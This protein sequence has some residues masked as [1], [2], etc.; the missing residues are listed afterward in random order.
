MYVCTIV[1]ALIRV[2]YVELSGRKI[3]LGGS[4]KHLSEV[5][6]GKIEHNNRTVYVA[7]KNPTDRHDHTLNR[8]KTS[9]ERVWNHWKNMGNN[10]TKSLQ[11]FWTDIMH[12]RQPCGMACCPDQ[13]I[14]RWHECALFELLSPSQSH[15]NSHTLRTAL[16]YLQQHILVCLGSL[17][18]ALRNMHAAAVLHCDIK[19]ANILMDMKPAGRI[20]NIVLADL[21]SCRMIGDTENQ[22][23]TTQGYKSPHMLTCGAATPQCDLYS[24]AVVIAEVLLGQKLCDFHSDCRRK[25]HHLAQVESKRTDKQTYIH[26][27]MHIAAVPLS[28]P[29]IQTPSHRPKASWG[30][31]MMVCAQE[32][33]PLDKSNTQVSY[34]LSSAE[35]NN[36]VTTH[37]YIPYQRLSEMYS[38]SADFLK[39]LSA[40]AGEAR[41]EHVQITSAQQALNWID[42]N[43]GS[44]YIHKNI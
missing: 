6:K 25:T 41:D 44:C 38:S 42:M 12:I 32:S 24:L 26:T 22:H 28:V 4:K 19:P 27:N 40:M 29:L 39:L 9:Y 14:F 5:Y 35:I 17:L 2:Q 3:R 23:G 43:L 33:A 30:Q 8:E 16:E 34:T 11:E 31:K 7:V 15:I 21:G 20:E 37:N 10:H 1:W 36:L 13:L 18:K